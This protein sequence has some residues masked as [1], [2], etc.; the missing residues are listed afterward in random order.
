MELFKLLDW[1]IASSTVVCAT[2]YWGLELKSGVE[3]V[4]GSTKSLQRGVETAI[5]SLISIEVKQNPDL[6]AAHWVLL[7]RAI[8]LG[9]RVGGNADDGGQKDGGNAGEDGDGYGS[10]ESAT[11]P[12]DVSNGVSVAE[13]MSPAQYA[14]WARDYAIIRSGGVLAPRVR[15]K[16]V[17]LRCATT[18]L[19]GVM[20]TVSH[21]DLEKSRLLTQ[22]ALSRV[23]LSPTDLEL[24]SLPCYTALFLHDVVSF[25][26]ACA[27]YSIED[28]RMVTLQASASEFLAVVVRMFWNSR[29]PDEVVLDANQVTSGRGKILQQFISQIISAV[30]T[31][32]TSPWHPVL[33]HTTGDLVFELIRGQLLSDK[34]VVKRVAKLL[35]PTV[36]DVALSSVSGGTGTEGGAAVD[37]SRVHLVKVRAPLSSVVADEVV[38]TRH[39]VSMSNVAKLYLLT[40]GSGPYKGLETEATLALKGFLESYLENF[41]EVWFAIAIDAARVLQGTKKWPKPTSKTDPRVGGLCYGPTVSSV[42]LTAHLELALPFVLAAAAKSP[43]LTTNEVLGVFVFSQMILENLKSTSSHH[44]IQSST[45]ITTSPVT[46]DV[47]GGGNGVTVGSTSPISKADRATLED[48]A[49]VSFASILDGKSLQ[50][51]VLDLVPLSAWLQLLQ[52]LSEK[53]L[54]TRLQLMASDEEEL[55]CRYYSQHIDILEAFVAQ[56]A[57]FDSN[58]SRND[59]G[60]NGSDDVGGLPT[61][62]NDQSPTSFWYP[63]VLHSTLTL[64]QCTVGILFAVADGKRRSKVGTSAADATLRLH[65]LPTLRAFVD[66]QGT[67][68]GFT[69]VE[70]QKVRIAFEFGLIHRIVRLYSQVI[71]SCGKAQHG[72]GLVGSNGS[73]SLVGDRLLWYSIEMYT[74]LIPLLS[75]ILPAEAPL[76]NKTKAPRPVDSSAQVTKSTLIESITEDIIEFGKLIGSDS[77]NPLEQVTKMETVSAN[78]SECVLSQIEIWN[79]LFVKSAKLTN[80]GDVGESA[81]RRKNGGVSPMGDWSEKEGESDVEKRIWLETLSREGREWKRIVVES[82]L[83]TW[84]RLIGSMDVSDCIYLTA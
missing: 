15:V 34:L 80:Q 74:K 9:L 39:I 71:S 16:C 12:K 47:G 3:T 38:T 8:A 36:A 83:S 64:F 68:I 33:L 40:T 31:C 50:K 76:H 4:L 65:D 42:R 29:D 32:L 59:T 2:L 17:A 62:G 5:D 58:E 27:T 25:A 19:E 11:S 28:H 7:C 41:T 45:S 24:E 63:I 56:V 26:C 54:P 46:G 23:S 75:C 21:T 35:L 67:V 37:D 79:E 55:K 22:T 44:S 52:F 10:F 30:R 70:I 84:L 6:R 14:A 48:L 49:L 53:A 1:C 69:S 82:C 78:C 18:A 81:E 57:K 61:D 20:H 73:V 43:F 72:V 60:L 51:N 77:E 13:H 66:D